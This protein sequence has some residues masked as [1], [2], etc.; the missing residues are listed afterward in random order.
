MGVG[1]FILSFDA[2]LQLEYH[3][4]GGIDDFD[5]V[6]LCQLVGLRGFSVCTQQHFDIVQTCHVV[7][8]D[9]DKAHLAQ[10]LA[11]HTI[12]Y[13]VTQTIERSALCQFLFC[14]LNGSGHAETEAATIVD[15]NFKHASGN[16]N[17]YLTDS[18][19]Q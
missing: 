18:E 6:T 1:Y 13:N 8:V 12:M 14:L 2:F 16:H 7:V 11:L 9:G 10:T 3:R 19:Q 5:I 17:T 4:T 15:F